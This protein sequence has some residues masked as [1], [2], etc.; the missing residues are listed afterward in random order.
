MVMVLAAR[1]EP[2]DVAR[3]PAIQRMKVIRSRRHS[4]Q[5]RGSFG[6][7]EGWGI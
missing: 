1:I 3:M 5:L 6:S 2:R 4:G 7:S